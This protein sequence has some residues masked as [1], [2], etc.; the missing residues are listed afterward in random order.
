MESKINNKEENMKTNYF[1]IILSAIILMLSSCDDGLEY[2]NGVYINGAQGADPIVTVALDQDLPKR[3]ELVVAASEI[4]KND[5]TVELKVDESFVEKYN[6]K[7]QTKY[8]MLPANCY[9]LSHPVATITKGNFATTESVELT[10]VSTEGMVEGRRYIV[11]VTIKATDGYDIIDGSDVVYVKI[12][13]QI[14]TSALNLAS[15][16][17]NLNF[18]KENT[19]SPYNPKA[20]PEVTFEARVYISSLGQFNTI[21]GLEENLTVRVSSY[22]GANGKIQ[23]A[24]GGV[25]FASADA[26]PLKK[27]THVALSYNYTD[28]YLTLYVDGNPW[29]SGSFT[30]KTELDKPLDLTQA[31]EGGWREG[32]MYIGRSAGGRSLDGYVSEVRV[33]ARAL[34]QAEVKSNICA[35]DPTE[36]G[37]MGYWKLNDNKPV[38]AFEESSGVG[39]TATLSSGSPSWIEGVKCP[40]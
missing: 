17:I 30:R 38:T 15:N 2:Y 32:P 39:Y 24:G 7:F 5:I 40:E 25:E 3:V 12:D 36:P 6:T 19:D 28:K 1:Y 23:I 9:V 33:W 21:F 8:T 16:Y 31:Y 11:P 22:G 14:I 29:I 4:A 20:L 18:H 35:V 10:L 26:F 27:W 34:S 37:L 13:Q